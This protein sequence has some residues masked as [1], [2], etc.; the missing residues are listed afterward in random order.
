MVL[1]LS[2][3]LDIFVGFERYRLEPGDSMHFPS[4]LPHRY[5]NPTGETTHAVTTILHD[6]GLHSPPPWPAH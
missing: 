3:T 4:A 2:G 5:V 6:E 1:V